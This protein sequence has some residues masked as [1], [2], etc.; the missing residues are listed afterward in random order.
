[1]SEPARFRYEEVADFIGQQVDRG[2]LHPGSRAPSLRE[3]SRQHRTSLTT[4]VQAYRLLEDRGVL[5]ARARSGFSVRTSAALPLPAATGSSSRPR[6]VSSSALMLTLLEHASNPRLV[7]LGCA[8]PSPELLASG[9]LDRLLASAAR[10]Q[11]EAL[12]VYLEPRGWPALRHQIARRALRWGHAVAEDR[13]VMTSGATEALALALKAVAK[14]GDVIAIES[15]TYFGLLEILRSQGLRALEISTDATAGVGIEA[16]RH[17]LQRHDVRACV[18]SSSFSNPSGGTVSDEG[19]QALLRL[20]SRH[21]VPLIED[22]VYGDLHFGER[23]P[24]PFS[25]FDRH[26]NVIYCGSFSKTL[27]PGYRMGW[28]ATGRWLPRILEAKF[29]TT[30]CA[31]VLPQVALAAYLASGGYDHHLRRLRRVFAATLQQMTY[32]VAESAPVGTSVSRPEGGFVL[33][34]EFD[35]RLDSRALFAKALDKGICFAPGVVF[36]AAGRHAHC[37]RLSGG[38]GWSGQLEDGIHRLGKLAGQMLTRSHVVVPST[39][40]P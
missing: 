2:V 17:A 23:R 33:W 6:D 27:A 19:K 35:R 31:P 18:L 14:P 21:R 3:I 4:A 38:F 32:A 30:L 28:V 1:V 11:G 13:I 39:I 37:L 24:A 26:D 40:R 20:L 16:L 29:A 10:R 22:D 9:R 12:N 36:S 25:A 15:P 34:L 8:I 5:E 7:P